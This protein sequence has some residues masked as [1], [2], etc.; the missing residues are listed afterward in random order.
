MAKETKEVGKRV[1]GNKKAT[2]KS[3]KK[4]SKKKESKIS[5]KIKKIDESLKKLNFTSVLILLLVA[6]S[7]GSVFFRKLLTSRSN[8]DICC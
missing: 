7:C 3:S 4:G 2:V 5:L 1:K 6:L 8:R